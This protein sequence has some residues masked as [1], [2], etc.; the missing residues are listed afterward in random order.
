MAHHFH[1]MT[2]TYFFNFFISTSKIRPETIGLF[3]FFSEILKFN[4]S[5]NNFILLE[6]EF[7]F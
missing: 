4:W 2:F 7:R 5:Y 3:L 6:H 1:L